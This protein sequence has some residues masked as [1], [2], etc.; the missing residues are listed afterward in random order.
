M[1]RNPALLDRRAAG[2]SDEDV[3]AI[4]A[5]GSD[6]IVVRRPLPV[7][8][9]PLIAGG[10]LGEVRFTTK[11]RGAAAKIDRGLARLELVNPVRQRAALADDILSLVC[12]MLTVF[13]WPRVDVR[14]DLTDEQTCPKF[15]CDNVVV[16]L[17][18]TYVGPGTELIERQKPET[19]CR[20]GPGSLVL[21]K[22]HRHPTHADRVLHR[23]P[24]VRWGT[25][26]FSVAIDRGQWL[27]AAAPERAGVV[28]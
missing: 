28:T 8:C 12:G 18:T 17:V 24:P 27:A 7:E 1:K 19:I 13:S 5:A 21:L 25:R 23:S 14:L 3:H 6:V 9:G 20:V 4:D 11:A 10:A 22:G 26:R 2:W 16:R 15:H